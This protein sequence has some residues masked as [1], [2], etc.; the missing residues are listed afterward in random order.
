VEH[1]FEMRERRGLAGPGPPIGQCD[2]LLG[3]A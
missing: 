2:R 3:H 1:G